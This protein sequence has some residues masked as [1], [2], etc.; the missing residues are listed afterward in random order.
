MTGSPNVITPGLDD[1]KKV[2]GLCYVRGLE[3]L[4]TTDTQ[5]AIKHRTVY[6]YYHVY[7]FIIIMSPL[8]Q[9][10]T[11]Y[12]PKNSL[13]FL[14][15]VCSFFFFLMYSRPGTIQLHTELRLCAGE[16]PNLH[17]KLLSTCRKIW[18][19]TKVLRKALLEWLKMLKTDNIADAFKLIKTAS[20]TV[21]NA[22]A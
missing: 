14:H 20:L 22:T 10:K 4:V 11:E 5:I 17:S 7:H 18:L 8:I 12:V 6:F 15:L 19:C 13:C 9:R 2:A 16:F 1:S 21:R 3:F